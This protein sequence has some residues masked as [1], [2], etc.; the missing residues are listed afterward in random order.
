MWGYLKIQGSSK[1]F[2]WLKFVQLCTKSYYTAITTTETTAEKSR[3]RNPP[4]NY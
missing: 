2:V 1:G 3:R 4:K